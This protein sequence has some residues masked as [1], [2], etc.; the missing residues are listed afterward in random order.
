MTSILENF[1][2]LEGLDGAG[3][4]TQINLLGQ[5]LEKKGIPFFITHEPTDN[6]TGKLIRRFLS[7]EPVVSRSTLAYAFAAD[8][9]DH[10]NNPVYGIRKHIENGEVVVSDRYL[11]SSLAYQS[12]DC[13][14]ATVRMLNSLFPL[15][16][17]IIY[18]DTPVEAS[19]SR[20]ESRGS[21][22]EIFERREYQ[23]KVRSNYESVFSD[24]P[25]GCT[26]IRVDG[27]LGIDGIFWE[28]KKGLFGLD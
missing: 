25:D 7:G 11:F 16:S 2:V 1:W 21:G 9:D 14:P 26:L 6:P 27:S 12:I 19:L 3:T 13:A 24:L 8:R 28:I 18:I 5:E 10:L 15:P 4:T 17:R 20:I 22:R 23:I